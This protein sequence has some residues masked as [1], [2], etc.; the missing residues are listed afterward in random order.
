LHLGIGFANFLYKVTTTDM[1][2]STT[3][4]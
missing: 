4:V 1:T 3:F 2:N